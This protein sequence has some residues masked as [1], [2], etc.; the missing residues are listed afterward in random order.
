MSAGIRRNERIARRD[1]AR[2]ISDFASSEGIEENRAEAL[3]SKFLRSPCQVVS[4]NSD[5]GA[6]LSG[7]A[8]G[9]FSAF[10]LDLFGDVTP[11][12]NQRC[13]FEDDL[14][15]LTFDWRII[16]ADLDRAFREAAAE[17]IA[18]LRGIMAHQE[19]LFDADVSTSRS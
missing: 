18:E 3:R 17:A 11:I 16:E 14:E 4:F 2:E 8:E 6:A 19:T 5:R 13:P 7:F 10:A 9:F 1:D 12:F 15:A